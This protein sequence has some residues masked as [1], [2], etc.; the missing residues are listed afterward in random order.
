MV[1]RL[2][3]LRR[4]L[5]ASFSNEI[6]LAR[7]DISCDFALMCFVIQRERS[8]PRELFILHHCLCKDI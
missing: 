1:R 3:L 7:V 4:A 2:L 8:I 5:L 6:D